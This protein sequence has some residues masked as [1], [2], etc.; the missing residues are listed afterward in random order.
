VDDHHPP[1]GDQPLGEPAGQLLLEGIAL[2]VAVVQPRDGGEAPVDDAH[3]LLDV[4]EARAPQAEVSLAVLLREA[5]VGEVGRAPVDLARPPRGLEQRAH[6]VHLRKERGQVV[7]GGLGGELAQLGQTLA[8]LV[9]V[10]AGRRRL[11]GQS[12]LHSRE[13][14]LLL[15]HHRLRVGRKARHRVVAEGGG[16]WARFVHGRSRCDLL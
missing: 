2:A 9:D 4:D 7:R 11:L 15:A 14:R 1:R 3:V 8:Q 6:H 10:A 16:G 13:Q 12:A 5:Q